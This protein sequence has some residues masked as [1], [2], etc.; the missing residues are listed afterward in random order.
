VELARAAL[1]LWEELRAPEARAARE[2]LSE[3]GQE[4]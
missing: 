3:L 2:L 1:A 4:P